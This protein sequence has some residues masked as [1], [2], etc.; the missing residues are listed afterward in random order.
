[1]VC[2]IAD[3]TEMKVRALYPQADSI[4]SVF[5]GRIADTGMAAAEIMKAASSI[6]KAPR[7]K[8]LRANCRESYNAIEADQCAV[9]SSLSRIQY[10]KNWYTSNIYMN[11][12]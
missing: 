5:A 4:V 10:L 2:G 7:T 6:C 12:P 8:L 11:I 3:L 9:P 1:M